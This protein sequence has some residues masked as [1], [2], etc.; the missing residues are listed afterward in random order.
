MT[1]REKNDE[2]KINK[3]E[4]ERK[5][6]RQK[7]RKSNKQIEFKRV[8]LNDNKQNVSYIFIKLLI[9]FLLKRTDRFSL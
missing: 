7:K 9:Q 1:K 8:K 6:V 2:K 3:R 4:A 5:R